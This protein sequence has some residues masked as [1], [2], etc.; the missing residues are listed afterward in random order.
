MSNLRVRP[1]TEGHK[2]HLRGHKIIKE[3]EK[4]QKQSSAQE[5]QIILWTFLN[6]KLQIDILT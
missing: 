4:K 6:L 3:R 2:I 5:I 1:P